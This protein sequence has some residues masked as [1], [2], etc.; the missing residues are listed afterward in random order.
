MKG[1]GGGGGRGVGQSEGGGLE[2]LEGLGKV[3]GALVND[4]FEV[5]DQ[6]TEV[7]GNLRL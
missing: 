6:D 2:N 1:R 5:K 3:A 7:V 4:A